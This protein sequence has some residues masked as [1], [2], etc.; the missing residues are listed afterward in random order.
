MSF[1]SAYNS[2]NGGIVWIGGML[3]G[4]LMTFKHG[5]RLM[6]ANDGLKEI[7]AYLAQLR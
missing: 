6:R 5:A 4:V 3:V 2:P 1:V 7:D